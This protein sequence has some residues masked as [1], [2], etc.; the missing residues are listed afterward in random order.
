MPRGGQHRLPGR[1]SV[2]YGTCHTPWELA[3][4]GRA[5]VADPATGLER[6]VGL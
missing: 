1:I 2:C 3:T 6:S 4:A 5:A